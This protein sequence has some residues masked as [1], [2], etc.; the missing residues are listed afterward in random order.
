MEGLQRKEEEK[1]EKIKQIKEM[2]RTKDLKA[3]EKLNERLWQIYDK[4]ECSQKRH[5]ES[6]RR[7]AS[8]ARFRNTQLSER[9]QDWRQKSELKEE[10]FYQE[11]LK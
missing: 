4:M 9:L 11:K 1:N 6:L 5:Q 8:E 10:E 3:E 2:K 7:V